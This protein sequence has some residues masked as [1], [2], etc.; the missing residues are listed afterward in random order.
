MS[1]TRLWIVATIIA[2]VVVMGFVFSVPRLRGVSETQTLTA[3]STVPFVTLKDVVKKGVHTITGSLSASNACTTI[4]VQA[5][6][7]TKNISLDISLSSEAGVCLQLPTPL[8]F[9]T[10]LMAP[11][12]LPFVVTVNGSVASTSMP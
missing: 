10:T 9:K 8:L 6:S 7:S 1:H 2:F 12:N 5:A 11:E 4:V 3:S